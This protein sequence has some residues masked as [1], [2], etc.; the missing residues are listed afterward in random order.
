MRALNGGGLR[1][2]NLLCAWLIDA[3][4]FIGLNLYLDAAHRYD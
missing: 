3:D 2:Y 1:E 4:G